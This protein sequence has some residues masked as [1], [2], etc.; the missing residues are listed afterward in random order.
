M[1]ITKEAAIK[2]TK[3]ARD[4][5]RIQA[6]PKRDWSEPD[7]SPRNAFLKRVRATAQQGW[8]DAALTEDRLAIDRD[9]LADLERE[10]IKLQW[11]THSVF[12]R[13][14]PHHASKFARGG[15]Q[16][17]EPGEIEGISVTQ[18]D[19][20]QLMAR[21]IEI[22]RKAREHDRRAARSQVQT[23]EMALYGGTDMRA[24][25][26]DHDSAR[27]FN[28]VRRHVEPIHVPED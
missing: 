25:G 6:A 19:G 7:S 3:A 26:A 27:R 21:P 5:Q 17:V 16:A 13:P 12:G 18:I 1:G 8:N 4:R 2:A 23:K 15:W 28:H 22:D 10:G 24:M 14:E 11:V 9:I 20:L